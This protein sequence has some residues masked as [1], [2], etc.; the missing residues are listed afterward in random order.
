[1]PPSDAGLC[2][3]V[4]CMALASFEGRKGDMC[5][6]QDWLASCKESSD[7][8]ST[9]KELEDLQDRS[10]E[11]LPGYGEIHKEVDMELKEEC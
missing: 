10:G 2:G 6:T 11:F 4:R 9:D 1:M 7:K 5:T 8:E 3:E